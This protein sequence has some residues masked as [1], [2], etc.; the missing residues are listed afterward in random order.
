[1]PGPQ[2]LSQGFERRKTAFPVEGRLDILAYRL[3]ERYA[4]PA[5]ESATGF[6][7]LAG[8]L[9]PF[10]ETLIA[11][12]IPAVDILKPFRTPRRRLCS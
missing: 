5:I 4:L 10:A 2:S 7:G 12:A 1:M 9:A 6:A 11:E 3:C 8:H